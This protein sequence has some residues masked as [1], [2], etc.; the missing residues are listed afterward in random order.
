MEPIPWVEGFVFTPRPSRRLA[1]VPSL[2]PLD[3]FTRPARSSR[4]S[5]PQWALQACVAVLIDDSVTQLFI[6]CGI[7]SVMAVI[8]LLGG[9][10]AN[11]CD[12]N[13]FLKRLGYS[14][15]AGGGRGGEG[16]RGKQPYPTRSGS[17]SHN[18]ARYVVVLYWVL[19]RVVNWL[20]AALAVV[21]AVS[22][23]ML[24]M[25]ELERTTSWSGSK[26]LTTTVMILQIAALFGECPWAH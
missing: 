7:Y 2:D 13:V 11:R 17:T 1:S 24:A 26:R 5:P 23:A 21:D 8:I 9:P 16:G 4:L 19:P 15:G 22:V 25:D 6:F 14:R 18:P 10:Y 20:S 3:H 12:E